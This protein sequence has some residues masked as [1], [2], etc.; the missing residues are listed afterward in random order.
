L[1]KNNISARVC[2]RWLITV[3][4]IFAGILFFAGDKKKSCRDKYELKINDEGDFFVVS[5]LL[6]LINN[7][8]EQP[9]ISNVSKPVV[10][11]AAI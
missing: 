11:K 9:A 6:E 3:V 2:N 5:L 8:V 10:E 1:R 4:A 7:K